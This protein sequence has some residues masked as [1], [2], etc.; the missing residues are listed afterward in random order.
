MY[1]TYKTNGTPTT[2]NLTEWFFGKRFVKQQTKAAIEM[3]AISKKG[4]YR[5]FKEGTGFLTVE[6]H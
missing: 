2:Q 3:N 6:I 4:S 1:I 5:F